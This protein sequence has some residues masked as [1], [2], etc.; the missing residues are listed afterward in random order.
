MYLVSGRPKWLVD[1]T[2]KKSYLVDSKTFRCISIFLEMED[3]DTFERDAIE[4]YMQ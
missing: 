4:I 2:C 1:G 3:N